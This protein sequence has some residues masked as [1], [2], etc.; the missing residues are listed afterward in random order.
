VDDKTDTAMD[1]FGGKASVPV[2]K[3]VERYFI[4]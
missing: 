4:P 3:A 1:R 2:E